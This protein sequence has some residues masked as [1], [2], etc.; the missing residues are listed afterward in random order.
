MQ[1]LVS[2]LNNEMGVSPLR[3]KSKTSIMSD[4]P[5]TILTYNLLANI[6]KSQ[7][8]IA[9]GILKG[10]SNKGTSK[11]LKTPITSAISNMH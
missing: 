5:L 2:I 7:W 6:T 8:G 11:D 9:R 4:Q 3:L 10:R 1:T